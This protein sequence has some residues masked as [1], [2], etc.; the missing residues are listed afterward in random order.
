MCSIVLPV[1]WIQG[2]SGRK[3]WRFGSLNWDVFWIDYDYNID[4]SCLYWYLIPTLTVAWHDPIPVFQ[5]LNPANTARFLALTVIVWRW[6]GSWMDKTT[7]EMGPT[8]V[9]FL[10]NN[11]SWSLYYSLIFLIG[12]LCRS[13]EYF[14]D[15]SQTT[16]GVERN[17]VVPGVNPWLSA[18]CWRTSPRTAGE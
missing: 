1:G 3:W 4:L 15:T 7:A 17:L 2:L 12:V 10:T 18:G 6:S 11:Y 13:H 16:F 5:P 9:Y 8:K 14:T